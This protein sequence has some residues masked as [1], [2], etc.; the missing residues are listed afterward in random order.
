MAIT[1][2]AY[3][4]GDFEHGAVESELLLAQNQNDRKVITLFASCPCI[5]EYQLGDVDWPYFLVKDRASNPVKQ[6]S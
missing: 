5:F 2:F 1:L 3:F 4:P 6:A